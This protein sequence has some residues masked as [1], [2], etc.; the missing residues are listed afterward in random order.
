MRAMRRARLDLAVLAALTLLTNF[1]YF[2]HSSGDFFYPDS[3][4]YIEP[5]KSML[6]G[7]GF[8]SPDGEVETFRTPGY[9]VFLLPFIA[10]THDF[11]S[12]VVIAQHL[13]NVAL[14]MAIYLFAR[15]RFSR[16]IAFAAAAIFAIDTPTIHYANKVLT[17]TLFTVGLFALIAFAL[18]PRANLPLL[19]LLAGALVVVRP[20]GIVYFIVLTVVFILE[21]RKHVA[22]FVIASLLLPVGWAARNRVRTGV[23]AIADVAG[24]NMLL[25]RAAG[26]LAIFD[27]YEFQDALKDRQDE[28]M[29]DAQ[30]EIERTLHIDD[31]GDLNAAQQA[32]WYGKIGRR[33]AL[34]HPLGLTALLTRGVFVNL[35]DSDAD[36]MVM[37]SRVPESLL[38]L[39]IEVWTHAI[40]LLA[41]FGT[42][43]LWRRDRLLSILI[44]LT[45]A[46]F[47]VI[48]AG[49]EA[50]ARFR[51]PIVPLLAIT[52]A[53]G[54]DAIRRAVA[55]DLHRLAA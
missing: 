46:Y 21:R 2:A 10:V 36:S 49:G 29:S 25:H 47:V 51:V 22:L 7:H 20:A 13:M 24:I 15:H 38:T 9:P 42:F 1:L 39:I 50:E 31:L 23:F 54:G 30:S 33:I 17:E 27:D 19:G 34:Q 12:A 45:I 41:L 11:A 28:V 52:A 55:P 40:T 18:R 6:A 4:T 35:F 32:M 44:A 43:L 8:V 5:A 3:A 37:V 16:G 26:S 48:S 14:A 53:I